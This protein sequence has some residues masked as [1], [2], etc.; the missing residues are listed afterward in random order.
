MTKILSGIKG[1]YVFNFSDDVIIVSQSIK[2]HLEHLREVFSRFRRAC[3]KLNLDKC[4]FIQAKTDYLG[5]TI[6]QHGLEPSKDK[7]N[8]LLTIPSPTSVKAVRSLVGFASYYRRYIPHFSETCEPLI[9]LTRK[10]V[11]FQW[12]LKC[13][14]ALQ[15]LK[16][17]LLNPPILAFTDPNKRFILY[18]DAS[19]KAIGAV[20]KQEYGEIEKPVHYLSHS[21]SQTQ[22]KW[23]VIEKECYAIIYSTDK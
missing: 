7:V 5:H 1:V 8:A 14:K 16:E 15:T 22:R 3:I 18:T 23:P 9:N 20:L 21:L 10:N 19:D 6:T 4:C 2:S 13:D 17:A 11:K 12:D